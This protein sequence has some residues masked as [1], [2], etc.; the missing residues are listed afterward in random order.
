MS[1]TNRH[2]KTEGWLLPVLLGAPIVV[3]LVAIFVMPLIGQ[4]S[5]AR[6]CVRAGGSYEEATGTCIKKGSKPL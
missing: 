1:T 4:H 5:E 3:G 2:F 6:E